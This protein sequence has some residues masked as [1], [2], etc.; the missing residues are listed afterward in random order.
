MVVSGELHA[1]AALRIRKKALVSTEFE[2]G[3][4]SEPVPVLWRTGNLFLFPEIEQHDCRRSYCLIYSY[5]IACFFIR[6]SLSLSHSFV[7][8]IS[9][10]LFPSFPNCILSLC[11]YLFLFSFS[12]T[13]FLS[14]S[15]L[16]PALFLY[17]FISSFSVPPYFSPLV[18]SLH[19]SPPFFL[20][21]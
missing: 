10:H 7:F 9:Q 8:S 16:L 2:A 18:T 19:I 1:P 6:I 4:T 15:L 20:C 21:F 14:F 17:W 11:C 5:V 12:F 13:L 3:S